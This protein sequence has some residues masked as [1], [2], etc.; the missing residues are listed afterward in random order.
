MLPLS[1]YMEKSMLYVDGKPVIRR[2]VERVR[3]AFPKMEIY[4]AV[5]QKYLDDVFHEFRDIH[6]RLNFK[7]IAKAV[8]TVRTYQEVAPFLPPTETEILLHYADSIIDLDYKEMV[9]THRSIGFAASSSADCTLAVSKNLKHEY[10]QVNF[11]QKCKVY[12]FQEK[13]NLSEYSWTGVAM[14]KREAV[15]KAI[16]NS[17]N[18]LPPRADRPQMRDTTQ[19][20]FGNHIFPTMLAMKQEVLAYSFNG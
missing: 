11:D 17:I 19:L 14:L 20:D 2:V 7:P 13:P 18:L 10:S 4:I 12:S 6:N 3:K 5:L 8:G 1:M 16:N 15:Q 9:Q